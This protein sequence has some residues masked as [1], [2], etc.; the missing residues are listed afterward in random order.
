MFTP[1]PSSDYQVNYQGQSLHEDEVL[2]AMDYTQG[3]TVNKKWDRQY[4]YQQP[5]TVSWKLKFWV[6]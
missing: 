1:P 5:N 2:K 4:T 6:P 3:I